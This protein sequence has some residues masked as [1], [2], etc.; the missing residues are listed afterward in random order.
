[1]RET[2]TLAED[3][4]T[5]TARYHALFSPI[6][7]GPIVLCNRA[8]VAPMT[9]TSATHEGHATR[10]MASYCAS[11]A[12]GGFALITTEGSYTDQARSQVYDNQPGLATPA[13]AAAW[14]VVVDAVHHGRGV[15]SS[16]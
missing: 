12:R 16:N 15:P 7:L 13:Q 11:V 6:R 2:A 10:Q 5:V 1:M 8:A 3:L 14:R 4:G 9:R